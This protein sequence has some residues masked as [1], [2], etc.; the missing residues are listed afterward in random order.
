MAVEQ[1]VNLT[2]NLQHKN[3]EAA[4]S[5]IKFLIKKQNN[6]NFSSF[7][8]M[9][10]QWQPTFTQVHI[11]CLVFFFFKTYTVPLYLQQSDFSFDVRCE[12]NEIITNDSS[13]WLAAFWKWSP[14][15]KEHL[16]KQEP[17]P[18]FNNVKIVCHI[19]V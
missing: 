4:L 6:F 15:W 19:L 11:V 14:K 10:E 1:W 13:T 3:E 16:N 18:K 7:Q 8:N 2:V 17:E 9:P 5:I 12:N